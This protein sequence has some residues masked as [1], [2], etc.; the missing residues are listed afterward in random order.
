MQASL[1][2][3]R[4]W[5]DVEDTCRYLAVKCVDKY[6]SDAALVT[7][8]A[9]GAMEHLYCALWRACELNWTTSLQWV[10][11]RVNPC[12]QG[13]TAAA[14]AIENGHADATRL[15]LID[16]RVESIRLLQHA[17]RMHNA[18]M[19]R[20]VL[21]HRR[22]ILTPLES[23]PVKLACCTNDV[24]VLRVLLADGCADE[25]LRSDSRTQR[26]AAN[27]VLWTRGRRLSAWCTATH[28]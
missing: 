7:A 26:C 28:N 27:A 21:K 13:N 15:L 12:M 3:Q 9:S 2:N 5:M 10:L 18:D 8:L 16:G 25:V 1:F 14:L 4:P 11:A 6:T 20:L 17:C 22:V 23:Y 24:P 19:V